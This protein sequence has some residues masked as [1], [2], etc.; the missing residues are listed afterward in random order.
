MARTRIDIDR[1]ALLKL[2][3]NADLVEKPAAA[4]AAACNGESSWGGYDYEVEV[5]SIR[6]RARVW[7]YAN[8]DGSTST[9]RANRLIRN[10]G[11]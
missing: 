2:M 5:S 1:A 6:A 11:G 4:T 7:T 10:L 9:E 8:Q 3:R